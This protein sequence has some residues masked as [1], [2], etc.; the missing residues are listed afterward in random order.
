[1]YANFETKN[2][3]ND[4]TDNLTVTNGQKYVAI[5]IVP[6]QALGAGVFT[7]LLPEQARD[8]AAALMQGADDVEQRGF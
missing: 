4:T 3:Y 6:G 8:L 1:M 7:G 2:S 5:T